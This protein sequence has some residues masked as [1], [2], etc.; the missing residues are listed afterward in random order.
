MLD[1]RVPDGGSGRRIGTAEYPKC[2]NPTLV[3]PTDHTPGA[4]KPIRQQ[5][6][7]SHRRQ[8]ISGGS[9]SLVESDP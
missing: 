4:T 1:S 8:A 6:S 3:A 5:F 7:S 2:P 9:G